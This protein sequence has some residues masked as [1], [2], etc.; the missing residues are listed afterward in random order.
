M[1]GSAPK[2]DYSAGEEAMSKDCG[3][4]QGEAAGVEL[5]ADLTDR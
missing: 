3:F 4:R 5:D 2:P 1:R